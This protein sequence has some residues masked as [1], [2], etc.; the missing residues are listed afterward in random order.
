[1]MPSAP[2][3]APRKSALLHPIALGLLL[4]AFLCYLLSLVPAMAAFFALGMLLEVAYWV[5]VLMASSQP[6]SD[7]G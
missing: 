3:P 5:A 1:M 7:S 4:L 2:S 6:P